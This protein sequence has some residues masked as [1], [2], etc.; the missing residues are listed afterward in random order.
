MVV[1][2]IRNLHEYMTLPLFNAPDDGELG[3]G[4]PETALHPQ[5]LPHDDHSVICLL[6]LTRPALPVITI[7]RWVRE[8][9]RSSSRAQ[10]C[11][12]NFLSLLPFPV[13]RS[14]IYRSRCRERMEAHYYF[15]ES[16]PIGRPSGSFVPRT[17]TRPKHGRRRHLDHSVP[18]RRISVPSMIMLLWLVSRAVLH[19]ANFMNLC[20]I[21]VSTSIQPIACDIQDL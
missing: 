17:T 7:T 8:R 21:P 5:E 6:S 15:G 18:C 20:D 9:G 11:Y 12:L 1:S 3:M 14:S 19:T 10:P 4:I 2:L 13:Q 16:A